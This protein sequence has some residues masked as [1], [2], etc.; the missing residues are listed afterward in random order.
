MLPSR[1]PYAVLF[2]A[3][4]LL[5]AP[6][7]RAARADDEAAVR[8]A[9]A[10]ERDLVDALARAE[11][12]TVA[13]LS[14]EDVRRRSAGGDDSV[15]LLGGVGSGVL[16]SER[17]L[18]VL[19]NHHVVRASGHLEVVT[20]NGRRYAVRVR[21]YDERV[22][23]ALLEFAEPADG[24][25]GIRLGRRGLPDLRPGT[26]VM[27]TG[28]PFFLGLDGRFVATLGV[29]S[30]I[31]PPEASGYVGVPIVQHDAEINPGNSG[32]PLWGLDGELVGINGT[33]ATR[34]RSQ[35]AG[36]AYTGASF[37]VPLQ[38]ARGFL[39]RVLAGP[40]AARGAL[41]SGPD[42]PLRPPVVEPPPVVTSVGVLGIRYRTQRDGAGRPVGAE[43]TA[44]AVGSPAAAH[45]GRG[46]L[47]PGDVIQRVTAGGRTRIVRTA[48]E[49]QDAIQG[50]PPGTEVSLSFARGGRSYAWSGQLA[51][52]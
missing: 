14:K 37:A 39:D 10:L 32:G 15:L 40:E 17:G 45:P 8:A 36:P 25:Q 1:A 26:W 49:L 28:N 12:S 24:L 4:A 6:G 22:D 5:L 33:I 23:L 13:V 43:V 9:R 52:R 34:S 20:A 38:E 11:A 42:V 29:V 48:Y 19:T 47:R 51:A 50:S 44:V 41:A 3:C 31:R 35:G 46:G 18:W 27:A 21:A 2:L 30:G 7:P 16:V